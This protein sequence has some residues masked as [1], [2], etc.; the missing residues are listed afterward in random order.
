MLKRKQVE[1]HQDFLKKVHSVK[2]VKRLRTLLSAASYYQLR[3][4]IL[5]LAA[6]GLKQVPAPDSVKTVFFNSHKKKFLREHF[7]SWTRVKKLLAT[8]N[9]RVEEYRRVLTEL[10]PLVGP[11]LS[12]LF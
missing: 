6:V 4:L 3:T 7:G 11:A 8:P 12:V 1:Q 5:I 10:A 2:S 9:Q